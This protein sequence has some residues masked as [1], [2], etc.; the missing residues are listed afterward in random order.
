MGQVLKVKRGVLLQ[1][2]SLIPVLSPFSLSYPHI[3]IILLFPCY[4]H[5][6]SLIPTSS[7]FSYSYTL[8]VHAFFTVLL[9]RTEFYNR[10]S[11]PT[12]QVTRI[13]GP[14]NSRPKIRPINM[15]AQAPST[16]CRDLI[17]NQIIRRVPPRLM[18]KLIFS[19]KTRP[20]LIR[21]QDDGPNGVRCLRV[22]PLQGR[23]W[24]LL[25]IHGPDHAS[26]SP[27]RIPWKKNMDSAK[28]CK[29]ITDSLSS[30]YDSA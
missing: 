13:V 23:L 21:L 24:V 12:T 10:T 15:V 26:S 22:H 29:P 2:N 17:C 30:T 6:L 27:T 28:P 11:T 3:I 1:Q 8:Q 4:H 14:P 19:L 20:L 5:S 7:T 16:R 18:P 9:H 25:Q